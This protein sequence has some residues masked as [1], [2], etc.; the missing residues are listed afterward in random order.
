MR[1]L[2]RGDFQSFS[3]VANIRKIVRKNRQNKATNQ[4]DVYISENS[5][6]RCYHPRTQVKTSHVKNV[7]MR[8]S[9]E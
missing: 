5:K 9:S 4:Q 8:E 3:E 1:K 7:I 6:V 2:K